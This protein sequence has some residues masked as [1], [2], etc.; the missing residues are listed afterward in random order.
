M[1]SGNSADLANEINDLI[2]KL[3]IEKP[4]ISYAELTNVIIAAYCPIV[5]NTTSL[6][7]SEKWRRMRQ[8]DSILQQQLAANTSAPG[9]LIIA[10]VLLPP[11]VYR[12]L[13][14]QAAKVDQSPAQL[15]AAILSRA[16]EISVAT[17]NS[18]TSLARVS[19]AGGIVRP[20]LVPTFL[21]P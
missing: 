8:F 10:N 19:R 20:A 5:A 13:R 1:T 3:Q 14:S 6:M 21:G 15:M 18:I 2:N 17:R 4:N 7:A 16:A 9:I 12:E 11:A